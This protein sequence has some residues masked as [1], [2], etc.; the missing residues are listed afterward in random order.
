MKKALFILAGAVALAL[1]TLGTVLPVLPTTPF[2]LLAF[3]CFTKSSEKLSKWFSGTALYQRYLAEY[4]QT[5]SMP[6]KQKLTIQ[7][8]AGAMIAI[9]FILIDSLV[10]RIL[11]ALGFFIYN[12]IF[13]FKIKTRKK[14]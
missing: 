10:V 11:L 4:M 13:I 6:L 14:P 9:S 5:K 1:G 7:V 2:L 3:Y 8:F 12:Y